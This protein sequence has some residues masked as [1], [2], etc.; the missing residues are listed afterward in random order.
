M[1]LLVS[2][3]LDPALA[4]FRTHLNYAK[5]MSH[6]LRGTEITVNPSGSPRLYEAGVARFQRLHNVTNRSIEMDIALAR[7]NHAFAVVAAPWFSVKC[8]Y[9][10]YYLETILVHRLDGTLVGFVK[11]GHGG[12]RRKMSDHLEQG[13]A[14]FSVPE[15]TRVRSLPDVNAVPPIDPGRNARADFWEKDVCTDSLL[16]KLAEYK[17]HDAKIGNGWNYHRP[18]HRDERDSFI[19]RERITPIDFFYWYRI[20][21]N[22]RDLD[23]IDFENGIVAE[24]IIA[25]MEAYNAAYERYA[26]LLLSSI[27]SIARR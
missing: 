16:K 12:V 3:P 15:L 19:A 23:Y 6:L 14:I 22:Y 25:Y 27:H 1:K 20:K 9:A 8:Y 5:R 10:L 2:P 21:A 24:D 26:T 11:R 13:T 17:M 4:S 18:T 7:E